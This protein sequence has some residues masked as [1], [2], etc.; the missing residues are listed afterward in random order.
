MSRRWVTYADKIAEYL[1]LVSSAV[2]ELFVSKY[3][4]YINENY[5]KAK[6]IRVLK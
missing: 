1:G 3:Y 2:L 6:G 4:D 5:E